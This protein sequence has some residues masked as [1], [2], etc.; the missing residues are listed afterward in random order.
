MTHPYNPLISYLTDGGMPPL[1]KLI[2]GDGQGRRLGLPWSVA[3]LPCLVLPWSV[4]SLTTFQI[5]PKIGP[6]RP[7]STDRWGQGTKVQAGN[8]TITKK[9]WV[10]P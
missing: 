2:A 10:L 3:L 4:P 1:R 6:A 8:G 5:I 9:N 7:A